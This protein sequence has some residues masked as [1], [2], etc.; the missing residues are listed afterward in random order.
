MDEGGLFGYEKFLRFNGHFFK[1]AEALPLTPD[2][3]RPPP[4]SR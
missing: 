1:E 3:H 2:R 4:R